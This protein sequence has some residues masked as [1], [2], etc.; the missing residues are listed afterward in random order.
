MSCGEEGGEVV[1]D[2]EVAIQHV[3]ETGEPQY[4]PETSE[5]DDFVVTTNYHQIAIKKEQQEE[6]T[7]M[8]ESKKLKK[9][10]LQQCKKEPRQLDRILKES[11]IASK[12]INDKGG[13]SFFRFSHTRLKTICNELGASIEGERATLY[14]RAYARLKFILRRLRSLLG[15][16]YKDW[17]GDQ[18]LKSKKFNKVQMELQEAENDESV[19]WD[20]DNSN[21]DQEVESASNIQANLE[22]EEEEEK[23]DDESQ[24]TT[25][26]VYVENYNNADEDVTQLIKYSGAEQEVGSKSIVRCRQSNIF[27]NFPGQ[28]TVKKILPYPPQL[29]NTLLPNV[30]SSSRSPLKS[31]PILQLPP[32]ILSSGTTTTQ[33]QLTPPTEVIPGQKR[34]QAFISDE[35]TEFP[36][37]QDNN[38]CQKDTNSKNPQFSPYQI[39]QIKQL[40]IESIEQQCQHAKQQLEAI[41]E[42]LKNTT[43]YIQNYQMEIQTIEKQCNAEIKEQIKQQKLVQKKFGQK[44]Y[45]EFLKQY[46]TF[47]DEHN[48]KTQ[49]FF[50]KLNEAL[51][52]KEKLEDLKKQENL[53]CENLQKNLEKLQAD[54]KKQQ[55][56][57][58]Q[59]QEG[60]QFLLEDKRDSSNHC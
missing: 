38:K 39:K 6:G 40:F 57:Y 16:N 53:V 23:N 8:D 20:G 56:E 18:K 43:S 52:N 13:I 24:A 3:T 46:C 36:I 41:E 22:E 26:P 7:E 5:Y 19:G 31:P 58:E 2:N 33:V 37:L 54:L 30:A 60:I 27:G 15:P 50:I 11:I 12:Y 45:L 32:V 1:M 35:D 10:I 17:I 55:Q 48:V 51:K 49:K 4:G 21:D 47:Q 9:L 25:E 34:K 59:M 42:K 28:T 14:S 44:D 29:S